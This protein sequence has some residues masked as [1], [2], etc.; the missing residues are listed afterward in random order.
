MDD[1]EKYLPR[2]EFQ[3]FELEN[4]RQHHLASERQTRV[5]GLL[6]HVPNQ[7]DT[8]TNNVAELAKE[9]RAR[10]AS[11]S[12]ELVPYNAVDAARSLARLLP[13]QQQNNALLYVVIG[14]LMAAVLFLLWKDLTG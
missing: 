8:L 12:T 5:E 6:S 9:V 11:Q 4:Q 2:V 7:L 1:N 13:A 14:L 10:G 3:R